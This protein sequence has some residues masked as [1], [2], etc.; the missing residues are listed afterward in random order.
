M[1]QRLLLG[2][3]INQVR[4][5]SEFESLAVTD[6]RWRVHITN[7]DGE[8]MRMGRIGLFKATAAPVSY[9][10]QRLRIHSGVTTGIKQQQTRTACQ[11]SLAHA[12]EYS[13]DSS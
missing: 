10:H 13:T 8:T 9:I 1:P 6:R 2:G 3:Q 5:M 11:I 4:N 7:E 12:L